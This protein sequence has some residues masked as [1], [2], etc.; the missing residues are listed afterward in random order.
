MLSA[1]NKA[2]VSGYESKMAGDSVNMTL[3]SDYPCL[4]DDDTLN[5]SRMTSNDTSVVVADDT[6]SVVSA[7]CVFAEA[8]GKYHG[9]VT[10]VFAT[11]GIAL[12]LISVIVLT[13]R[14][15]RLGARQ[16]QTSTILT[17]L[18]L[19]DISLLL[20][21]LIYNTVTVL[22]ETQFCTKSCRYIAES[23]FSYE[24]SVTFDVTWAVMINSHTISMCL[25]VML[26]VFRYL[27]VCTTRFRHLLCDQTCTLKVLVGIVVSM[28]LF[29]TPTYIDSLCQYPKYELT[30]LCTQVPWHQLYKYSYYT[31]KLASCV[32]LAVFSVLLIAHMYKAHLRRKHKLLKRGALSR[33]SQLQNRTT[34]MLTM[35]VVCFLVCE[36]PSPVLFFLYD[37]G[38]I[39]QRVRGPLNF[40]ANQ[41][42]TFNNCFNDFLYFIMSQTFRST[43]QQLA[44]NVKSCLGRG[45]R[46]R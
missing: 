16:R 40:V 5:S 33:R 30:S 43:F 2:I 26:A 24:R 38:V 6:N 45:E 35:L 4:A 27:T 8:Y 15:M 19:A 10:V 28:L 42:A 21:T 44:L 13:R 17:A 31:L 9:Y 18:A 12:N 34:L 29:H 39:E 36:L 37:A 1:E 25:V 11:L 46:A 32:A 7:L 20:S 23:T 22:N 14:E 41:L 3:L